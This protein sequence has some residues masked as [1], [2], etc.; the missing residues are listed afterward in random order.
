MQFNRRA[1]RQRQRDFEFESLFIEELGWNTYREEIKAEIRE[2]AADY[3][4]Y[5]LTAVAQKRGMVVF[6]CS[7]RTDGS[8][9]DHAARRKIQRWVAKSVHE[10]LIIY[11]DAERTTQIWQCVKREPGK[12][13][14]CPEHRYDSEQSGEALVQKLERISFSLEEDKNLTLVDV[15]GRVRAAFDVERVTKKFY[16]RFKVE[17][18]EFL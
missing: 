2:S 4:E 11:T 3:G 10:H 8:M 7:T 6:Q 17:H 9:P 12:P 5:T 14:A 16:D 15:T 13:L 1:T 18:N